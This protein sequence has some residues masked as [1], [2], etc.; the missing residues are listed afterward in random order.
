[1]SG[2]HNKFSSH[3]KDRCN[4]LLRCFS[5]HLAPEVVRSNFRK[6]KINSGLSL[7]DKIFWGIWTV[8][9]YQTAGQNVKTVENLVFQ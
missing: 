6:R 2:K 4:L 8:W 1:M 7:G 5:P 9:S 3:I